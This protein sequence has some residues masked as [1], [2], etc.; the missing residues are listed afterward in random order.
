MLPQACVAEVGADANGASA[1]LLRH[2][3]G[4]NAS[5]AAAIVAGRPSDGYKRRTELRQVKGIGPKS[6]EQARARITHAIARVCGTRCTH[7]QAAGFVRIHGGDEPLDATAVHPESYDVA[8]AMIRRLGFEPAALC[9]ADAR[10]KLSDAARALAE[11]A[12]VIDDQINPLGAE[13]ETV[14]QVPAVC[15]PHAWRAQCRPR[16]GCVCARRLQVAAA[17]G[18]AWL[19]SR[20]TLD[21]PLLLGSEAISQP[22]L[23]GTLGEISAGSPQVLRLEDVVAGQRLRGVVRNVTPFG[24]FVDVV[25]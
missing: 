15:A 4:L 7:A 13:T 21:G 24:A 12:A 3:P 2:V 25:R 10:A 5:R 17:L 18:C 11:P 22:H 19:D 14:R 8:R 20:D 23:G 6:Y 1:A 16:C 9:D